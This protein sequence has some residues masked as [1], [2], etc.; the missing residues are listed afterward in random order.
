[1]HS[2]TPVLH[3]NVRTADM[4]LLYDP[5]RKSEA[6]FCVL[7]QMALRKLGPD[8]KVRRNYPYLGTADGLTAYLRDCFP[9]SSYLGVELE[10]NQLYPA[11]DRREWMALQQLILKSLNK[12]IL[13]HK[14][15]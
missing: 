5:L 9:D 7:W 1:V 14:T 12:A 6:A 11:E 4:G 2:F 13:R 8:L 15:L 10:V 3:G